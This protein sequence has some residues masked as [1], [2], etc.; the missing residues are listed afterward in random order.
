MTPPHQVELN[1]LSSVLS[2]YPIWTP[3]I[4]AKINSEIFFFLSCVQ[5]TIKPIRDILHYSSF[6]FQCFDLYYFLFILSISLLAL[7][8]CSCMLASL[9]IRTFYIL[10]IVILNYW[11]DNSN[12]P[13][14]SSSDDCSVASNCVFCLLVCLVIFFLIAGYDRL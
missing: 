6:L 9:S 8:I 4:A 14:V 11:S 3:I 7:T 12:I 1:T 10:I 5:A 2:P 13:A